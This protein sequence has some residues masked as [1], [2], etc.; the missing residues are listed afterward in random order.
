MPNPFFVL[1]WARDRYRIGPLDAYLDSF[2]ES[3]R[4][5]GY[6]YSTGQYYVH[7]IGH[8][9]GWLDRKG[10]G[11]KQIKEETIQRYLRI[12]RKSVRPRLSRAI[13][14]FV[15]HLQQLG[16]I[17]S[18]A[19]KDLL[20]ACDALIDRF[21]SHLTVDRGLCPETIRSHI[22]FAYRFVRHHFGN[23]AI[24]FSKLSAQKI[25]EYVLR[26]SRRVSQGGAKVHVCALRVFLRFLR[27]RGDISVDLASSV[28]SVPTWR[29]SSLP[30]TFSMKQVED[31]VNSCERRSPQG[32]RD[33]AILL[34][35]SRLGLRAIEVQRM[36]LEDID[37]ESGCISVHG[38]DA[39][40][41]RLP[42]PYDVGQA[43]VRYLRDGRPACSS[44][45]VFVRAVAPHT[46]LANS[47]TVSTVARKAI[48]QAGLQSPRLGSHVL[49]HACATEMLRNGA[50]IQEIGQVLRH[51]KAETTAIYAKVDYSQLKLMAQPWPGGKA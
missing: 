41:H 48:L 1:A 29:L 13:H 33:R 23:E 42:L 37:W 9:S 12:R 16:V 14:L 10:I 17:T 20:D 46:G 43:L 39:K 40:P 31:I 51:R 15:Q 2:A 44:R 24:D 45:R 49:R 5:E 6:R 35:L 11:I 50:S 4:K 36:T 3:L 26:E 47:S 25:Q 27:S 32:L 28:P 30:T 18:P 38:K 8:L 19:K 7:E 22:R 34:L 21:K